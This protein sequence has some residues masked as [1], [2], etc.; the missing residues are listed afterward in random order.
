MSYAVS[1]ELAK[2]KKP[3]SDGEIVKVCAVEMAKAFGDD[4]MVKHFETAPTHGDAQ[5]F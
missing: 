2:A 1:L 3:L 5:D 4:N